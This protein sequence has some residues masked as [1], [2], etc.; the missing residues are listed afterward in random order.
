MIYCFKFS[1]KHSVFDRI[2]FFISW[3][4]TI[5]WPFSDGTEVWDCKKEAIYYW[6]CQR[7]LYNKV[8]HDKSFAHNAKRPVDLG[9][10]KGVAMHLRMPSPQAQCSNL[11]PK[12]HC[13]WFENTKIKKEFL[14]I[15]LKLRLS[16]SKLTWKWFQSGWLVFMLRNIRVANCSGERL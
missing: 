3:L 2:G 14:K 1:I 13:K 10:S 7:H 15:N 11:A 4:R 5:Q 12:V 16:L 8:I 9:L 6:D